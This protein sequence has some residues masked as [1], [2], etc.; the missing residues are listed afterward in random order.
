MEP[1]FRQFFT[2]TEE[3]KVTVVLAAGNTASEQLHTKVPQKF[4]T[5][6]NGIITVG[7]VKQ[8][9]TLYTPTSPEVPGQ[10]GSMTV[11]APAV[12]VVV[13][14]PGNLDTGTSQAAAIVV[15]CILAKPSN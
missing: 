13:P 9:G 1:L 2:W 4:G 8:D 14:G 11:Y 12:D 15:C 5:P 3:N 6:T 7:G 10:S